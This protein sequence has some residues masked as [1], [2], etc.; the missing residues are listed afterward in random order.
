MN[1]A[2][3]SPIRRGPMCSH[4]GKRITLCN[5]AEELRCHIFSFLSYSEIIL[6]ALTCQTMYKTVKN[7]T[8]LQ[9]LIELGAQRLM[10]VHPRPPT[11][12]IAECLRIL[13]DKANAWSSFDLS[14][15]KRLRVPWFFNPKL[16]T[17]TH[18]KLTLSP[19]HGRGIMSKV[20]DIRTC[21][22]ET[23]RL[24]PC[25]WN[26]GNANPSPGA[27]L[28]YRYLDETQDLVITVYK[29]SVDTSASDFMYQIHFRTISTDKEHPLAHI[30]CLELTCRVPS[31]EDRRFQKSEVTVLGGRVAFY[32]EVQVL[33]EDIDEIYSYWSLHVW[34]WC[35]GGQS[36]DIYLSGEGYSLFEIRFLTNEKLLSLTSHCCI[37]NYNVED[38]SNAPQLQARFRMPLISTQ[39][40][41][42]YPSVFHSTSS[43]TRLAAPDERWIWTTNPEDRVICV[44][45]SRPWSIFVIRA[46]LFFM[47]IPPSW[48]DA[49]SEDKLVVP[50]SSW[51]PH[52]SRYLPLDRDRSSQAVSGVGGS[53]IMRL[54]GTRMHMADFNPSAVARGVGKIVREP[55]TIPTRSMN[56]FT[57]D[58][59]THLPY[60]E[61]VNNDREFD[62]TLWDVIL[63]EEKVLIITL[64]NV[65]NEQAMGVEIIEM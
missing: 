47:D 4:P 8:E 62:G 61:V 44:K 28:C 34:S 12:S 19:W 51:G 2:Q 45:I 42:R 27:Y 35:D 14:V 22:P 58:V 49:A 15:T 20:I 31:K 48:F 21:T 36:D 1:Q 38:L 41:F 54:V 53:R 17:I 7:S 43:C 59:T 37:E 24:P 33:I 32:H 10:P 57:E 63:D 25:R 26:K 13:R 56:S 46:Q 64:A 23:A 9:Y 65:A 29:L 55:T 18:Q 52:N 50:W 5:I 60:V 39:L 6:C 30:S 11:V 40:R 16:I 3:Q